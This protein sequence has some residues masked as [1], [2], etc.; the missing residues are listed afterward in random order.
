V[1]LYVLIRALVPTK[2]THN[3][4]RGFFRPGITV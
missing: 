4:S 2:S 3:H 1:V